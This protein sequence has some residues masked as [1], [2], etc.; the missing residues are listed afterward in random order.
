MSTRIRNVVVAFCV[1]LAVVVGYSCY[2]KADPASTAEDFRAL[3]E[4][5]TTLNLGIASLARQIRHLQDS[6]A[7]ME[8]GARMIGDS[9]SLA[10]QDSTNLAKKTTRTGE[11]DRRLQSP[12]RYL[13]LADSAA[14]SLSGIKDSL[15]SMSASLVRQKSL[16]ARVQAKMSALLDPDVAA[17]RSA[18]VRLMNPTVIIALLILGGVSLALVKEIIGQQGMLGRMRDSEYARGLITYL[19]AVVTIGTAVV[20]VVS[21]LLGDEKGRQDDGRQ[22]LALLLGV[23]GTIVGFYFGTSGK[24]DRVAAAELS[25]TPPLL[26]GA[27]GQP[28]HATAAVSGGVPPYQFAVGL[29]PTPTLDYNSPVP[30]DGWIVADVPVPSGTPQPQLVTVGVKDA[31][32]TIRTAAKSATPTV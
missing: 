4:Y 1:A 16:D 11:E 13:A 25:L 22:I 32:G 8:S 14:K 23:F 31:A 6:V 9:V 10:R 18:F 5:S 28:I 30:P 26:S 3:A 17:W 24:Q 21:A 2:D 12:V 15:I 7:L 29:G 20:L 27:A 19:Y